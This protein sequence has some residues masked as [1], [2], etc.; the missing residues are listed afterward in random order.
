MAMHDVAILGAGPAGAALACALAPHWRVVLI[1]R[2]LQPEDRIGEALVPAAG[3]VL[4]DLGLGAAFATLSP[5]P[6]SA[7]RS[8][9]GSEREDYRDFISDPEGC[10]WH[11]DRAAFETMLRSQAATRGADCRFGSRIRDIAPGWRLGCDGSGEITARFLVDASGRSAVLARRL[12]ARRLH[13]DRMVARWLRIRTSDRMPC[14]ISSVVATREG[15]WYHMAV[16]RDGFCD[17]ILAFHG[18]PETVPR[19]SAGALMSE[20]ARHPGLAGQ[21]RAAGALGKVGTT[22]AHTARLDRMSG[23]NWLAIGDAAVCFDPL[24]SRGLFH[25]L[26]S[27]YVAAALLD[28][29]LR[30]REDGFSLYDEEMSRIY[31]A[32]L[33]HRRAV[34]RAEERWPDTR[35][36]HEAQSDTPAGPGLTKGMLAATGA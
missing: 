28:G 2:A 34:Y 21:L 11:L 16:R 13:H 30:G 8:V 10:G 6:Y 20:A 1:D 15:W 3:R 17:G 25:A 31:A 36:W 18:L 35:F 24:A 14:G 29:R 22:A 26:Y 12:G 23:S 7:N 32:Y 27:A 9:W 33:K 5:Q 4:T 19:G